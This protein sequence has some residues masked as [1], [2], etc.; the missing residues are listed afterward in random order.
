MKH[1]WEAKAWH[2]VTQIHKAILIAHYILPFIYSSLQQRE[3]FLLQAL[4]I[5]T[6]WSLP[7][8]THVKAA[9]HAFLGF[10]EGEHPDHEVGTQANY[11]TD[12]FSIACRLEQLLAKFGMTLV[13]PLVKKKLVSQE[14]LVWLSSFLM[15]LTMHWFQWHWQMSMVLPNSTLAAMF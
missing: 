10:K 12:D 8:S 1:S 13:A 11:D 4:V 7:S 14:S 9:H 6:I 2:A 5:V 3:M 15:E